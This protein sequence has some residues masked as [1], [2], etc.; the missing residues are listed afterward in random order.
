MWKVGYEAFSDA[1]RLLAVHSSKSNPR[2]IESIN[3]HWVKLINDRVAFTDLQHIH[4]KLVR[5]LLHICLTVRKVCCAAYAK[6]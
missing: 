1:K 6:A 2:M 3:A 5:S 4:G